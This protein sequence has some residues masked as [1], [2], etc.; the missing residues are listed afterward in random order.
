LAWRSTGEWAPVEPDD[1]LVAVVEDEAAGVQE[2]A[3]QGV[4]GGGA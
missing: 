2:T 4:G 3:L 1:D